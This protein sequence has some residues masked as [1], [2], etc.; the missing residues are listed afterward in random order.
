M[1]H[2]TLVIGESPLLKRFLVFASILP[3]LVVFG[4][5]VEE[6]WPRLSEQFYPKR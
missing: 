6:K 3:F 2:A 5:I 1:R 4:V